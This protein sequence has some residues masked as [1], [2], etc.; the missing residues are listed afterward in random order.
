MKHAFLAAALI[1]ASPVAFADTTSVLLSGKTVRNMSAEEYAA[2]V[3]SAPDVN[4]R[5][6]DG[7]TPPAPR[8]RVRD[9]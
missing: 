5:G 4:A 9:T 8:G 1:I 7:E 6:E 3:R 2:A